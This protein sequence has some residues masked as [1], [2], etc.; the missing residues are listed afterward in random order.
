VL[1]ARLL[2]MVLADWDRHDDQWRWLAYPQ[3]GGGR[4]FRPLPRDR[5][6]ALFVNQGVL[7]RRASAA[8]LLPRIQGFNYTF[9]N[10]NSFNFNGRYF[11]HSFLTELNRADWRALAD[12]VQASL[13][14]EVLAAGLRQWPDSIYRLSGPTILAKLQA[15]RAHLPEWADQYYRFLA[16]DV[17]VVGSDEAEEFDV[18]HHS[19]SQTQVTIYKL[20]PNGKHE[21]MRYQRTFEAT[22]TQEIRLFGQGGDDVFRLR[23]ETQGEP[24]V[25]VVG[26]AG[27]DTLH[28]TSR[29]STGRRR[30]KAYDVPT[31][32]TVTARGP[33]TKLR[34][35]ARPA[36]NLYDRQAFQ[37]PYAGPLYPW[38]YN[39]DDG[40]FV[41]I[42]LLL[43]RPGFRK[44][45][46]AATHQFT[47][48]AALRTGA[49]SFGYAG[50]FTQI[51]GSFDL[52]LQAALQAPNYVRNFYGLGNNTQ[53][54][55]DQPTSAAY[56]RVRFRNLSLAA[57]LR[58]LVGPRGV[59]F[60]GPTYQGVDV[61]DQPGR[62]LDHNPDERLHP[63]NLFQAK[64]YL[65]ARLG[66]EHTSLH[67]R[68][69]LP[70]GL[71]GQAE[72]VALR[73]LTASTRPLTQL[74]ASLALYRSFQ[75]PLRLTLAT[76]FGG[77]VNFSEDYE[78][79]QAATLGGLA[80]LRGFGRTRFAGRQSAY[81]NTEVRLQLARFR[82]YLVPATLGIMGFHDVGRVWVPGEA[83]RSWHRGYGPGLWL[84][85]T[86]QV[87]LAAMYGFSSEGRLPL[88]R[89]GFF[90]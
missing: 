67:A 84:A 41:G 82:S 11:D 21:T 80:N 70:Q 25:R 42:G 39:V 52:Q 53:L 73:P 55:P 89:L 59:V 15:H 8:Y 64:Q 37:Y 36:V 13:S 76:R 10:V 9:R 32:L 20:T 62:I 79:F 19:N 57:L 83:S 28:D 50:N 18:V 7:P 60:G 69:E 44:A 14:D 31:G 61:E 40:L 66:Y 58:H 47:A 5:D 65:G 1:R 88:V 6:Q 72:L 22:E 34:L 56:Y 77:T 54:V 4:L 16:R 90:F 74:N 86:P 71:A 49:F 38:S 3:P 24:V 29:S 26:G 45:P 63:A 78:F 30:V 81:N 85:P 68:A 46:W 12:S 51:V 23:G 17:D 43:K 35:S 48:N 2:D 33:D 75:F 27:A 87:V